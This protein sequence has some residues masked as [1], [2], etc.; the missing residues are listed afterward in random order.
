MVREQVDLDRRVHDSA[1]YRPLVLSVSFL[2]A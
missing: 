1:F 2:D